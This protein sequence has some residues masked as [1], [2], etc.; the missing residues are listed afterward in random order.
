MESEF[1]SVQP[2]GSFKFQ[3]SN[4]TVTML[5]PKEREKDVVAGQETIGLKIDE[6]EDNVVYLKSGQS[7]NLKIMQKKSSLNGIFYSA[8]AILSF[9]LIFSFE[10]CDGPAGP[11]EPLD[12]STDPELGSAG[13]YGYIG[14]T[15]SSNPSD[16]RA[17]VS[18][19]TAVWELV[20]LEIHGFQIGLPGTWIIPDNRD[21]TTIALCP[22]GTLASTWPERGPT[23]Q[24]VFQTL[25]GGL[26]YWALN[27]FSYGPPKFSMNATSQC[28]DFEIASPGWSFFYNDA[29]LPDDRLGIAQLSN[30]LLIPPDGITFEGSPD[31]QFM[32][33]SYM[34]L[35]F[36]DP[37]VLAV[38]TGDQS[39]TCFIN[40]YNFKGPIAYYLPETWSR[41]SE[42]YPVI[43]GRGLDS[44]AGII[45]GGAMEINRVPHYEARDS[46]GTRYV[47]IPQLRFPVN[48][49]GDAILVQDLNFYS[50]DA[51][52]NQFLAWRN[53][54]IAPSGKFSPGGTFS[55]GI[56]ANLPSLKQL[57][58]PIV[59]LEQIFTP[60]AESSL[61]GLNWNTTDYKNGEFP[62]YFKV[63]NGS[64]V[65]VKNDEVPVETKL[66]EAKFPLKE[67]KPAYTSPSGGSWGTPGPSSD[68]HHVIL[69]D[70]S[71]V[72]YRWYKFI[73]QPVF[74]QYSWTDE[75]KA[76]LQALVEKIHAEWSIHDDYIPSPTT[77]DLISLD[78][79]LIVHPPEGM[80][81]GYVPIVVR[82]E[83]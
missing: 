34:A 32:G 9:F 72:T 29:A 75:K 14:Y 43:E 78:Y 64:T 73:D 71:R 41:L 38:T 58:K 53:G 30:R 15:V 8:L 65:P 76:S 20:D 81:V 10:N 52:Y 62:Q 61:F 17:G 22:P 67:N 36:T 51:L 24:D 19:Y 28:Y 48:E 37:Y 31:I 25:E 4:N 3:G 40:T 55:P 83:R 42:T 5:T 1:E 66:K 45:H 79:N 82:Q 50:K 27:K 70:G 16:F 69:N 7:Y 74:Q 23:F 21:N 2:G 26:G 57:E 80:E 33:Y 60:F 77:G 13:L 11:S 56:Y 46:T 12:L 18:F 44:R 49:D 35:P 54:G 59:G 6:N 68:D 47:K 39:W 63:Q